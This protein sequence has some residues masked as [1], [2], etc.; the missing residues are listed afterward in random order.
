[1]LLTDKQKPREV[2]PM[3]FLARRAA[4]PLLLCL[5][6]AAPSAVRAQFVSPPQVLVIREFPKPDLSGPANEKAGAAYIAAAKAG[7]PPIHHIALTSVT[8]PQRVLFF[9]GYPSFAALEA[10]DKV[11]EKNPSAGAAFDHAVD[12]S[13]WVY[14]AD[15][16]LN[17]RDLV[18]V[19]YL[20]YQLLI[21]KPGRSEEFDEWVKMYA[22][23][24][25]GVPGYNWA[26]YQQVF[27]TN[28]YAYLF[29]AR[30]K[31]LSEV[32]SVWGVGGAATLEF[33]KALGEAKLKKLRAMW[34][35]I[36]D[37]EMTNLFRISPEMSRPTDDVIKAEPMFWSP[38]SVSV[39]KKPAPAPA[40]K[41]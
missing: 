15:L 8:G 11:G 38:T 19:R 18:G 20:E 1:M 3:T 10:E 21:A 28:Y 29:I 2:H 34:S 25:K 14:R 32:D 26:T 40:S 9:S 31:S 17:T 5:V 41:P 33:N 24:Y 4:M 13:H 35:V 39:V 22:E 36:V 27:G 12:V 7:K 30:Y 37:S 16:S 6:A 23:G